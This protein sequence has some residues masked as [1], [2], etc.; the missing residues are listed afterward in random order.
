M[1]LPY[2]EA[3]IAEGC[4]ADKGLL[5]FTVIGMVCLQANHLYQELVTIQ[6]ESST[7]Q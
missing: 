6:L 4:N 7:G 3:F 1:Q 5:P 2:T